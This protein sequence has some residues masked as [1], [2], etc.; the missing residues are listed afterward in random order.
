LTNAVNATISRAPGPR[1]IVD[2]AAAPCVSIDDAVAAEGDSGDSTAS[3][4]VWLT[5]SSGQTISVAYQTSDGSAIGGADYGTSQGVV[6]F[7][8]GV[9]TQTVTIPIRGDL[10]NEATETFFVTLTNATNASICKAQAIG[11][12]LDND[13]LP[14]IRPSIS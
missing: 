10:L 2:R 4:N 13:P 9:L 14:S 1:Q 11:R 12:I 8:P 6:T 5:S 7:A 3:F